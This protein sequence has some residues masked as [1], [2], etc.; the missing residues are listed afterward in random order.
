[1]HKYPFN[2]TGGSPKPRTFRLRHGKLK[3]PGCEVIVTGG[4]Y[5]AY[6]VEKYQTMG[7]LKMAHLPLTVEWFD[8]K[9][10]PS[11]KADKSIPISEIYEIKRGHQTP[12][13]WSFAASRGVSGMH[14]KEVRESA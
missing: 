12:T 7:V 2:T 13:F 1:M 9:K 5:N 14:M 4:G 3:E 6:F 8:S 11:K 10:G